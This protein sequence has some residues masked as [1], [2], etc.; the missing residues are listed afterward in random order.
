M[1]KMVMIAFFKQ[2]CAF[3]KILYSRILNVM[4]DQKS[5]AKAGFL[6]ERHNA[7]VACMFCMQKVC[8]GF[9]TTNLIQFETGINP[10]S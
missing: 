7:V 8:G 2:K 1:G 5:N 4:H 3:M 9:C 10:V 6:S